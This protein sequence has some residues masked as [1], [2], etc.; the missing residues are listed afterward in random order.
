MLPLV[1]GTVESNWAWRLRMA[2]RIANATDAVSLGVA[3]LYVVGSTKEATAG[4]GSDIDLI[5]HFS[6]SEDQRRMLARW[7]EA[8]SLYLDELNFH[9]TGIRSGGLLDIHLVSDD[10]IQQKTSF[11]VMIDSSYNP[12]FELPLRV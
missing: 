6:G 11:A 5:V 7:L 4:P 10:D 2:R 3:H 8:W 1:G 12:A 9:R